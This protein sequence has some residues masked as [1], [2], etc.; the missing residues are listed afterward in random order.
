VRF[1]LPGRG[2]INFEPQEEALAMETYATWARL[3]ELQRYYS[4]I[5]DRFHI[6]TRA[7][8]LQAYQ[9]DYDFAWLEQRCC[10]WASAWSS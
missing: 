2:L 3:F 4:W 9:T 7:Y 8:Q 1:K 6:S 5:V 10:P